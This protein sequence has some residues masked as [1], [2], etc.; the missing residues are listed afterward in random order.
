MVPFSAIYDAQVGQLLLNNKYV[1]LKIRT[2]NCKDPVDNMPWKLP[3]T[4][5]SSFITKIDARIDQV[6]SI[7]GPPPL[8]SIISTEI[9]HLLG[10]GGVNTSVSVDPTTG[11]HHH[12]LLLLILHPPGPWVS[13]SSSGNVG[14]HC[15][16]FSLEISLIM[17][18]FWLIFHLILLC[19]SN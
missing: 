16:H 2:N 13:V 10:C 11:I 12:V 19:L 14:G 7:D 9:N 3:C 18:I 15:V 4:K 17:I 8:S 5:S 6:C 1:T